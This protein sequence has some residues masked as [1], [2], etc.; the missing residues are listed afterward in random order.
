MPL[1]PDDI[2]VASFPRS[3][4][5]WT[6][7]L[8][9]LLASDLDY[10]KAAAIP[11]QARYTFL[12]FSMYLSKEILNAV[13]N[14]NAGK[15]DQLKILDILSAPGS[16]LAAQMSSPRFLKTHLPMSLLPPTLL[17]S[18]KVLYVARNPTRRSRIVLSS[19]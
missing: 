12:E 4:T 14:E 6:Q 5:T 9:W 18:T 17:D 16:Q 11:L 10:S 8:V 3:G 1:R 15:E 7:E 19:Q 2:F 13:K